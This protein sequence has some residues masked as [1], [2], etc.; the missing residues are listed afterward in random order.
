VIDLQREE[1]AGSR[2]ERERAAKTGA[3]LQNQLKQLQKQLARTGK[4]ASDT[5]SV[6][7]APTGLPAR[8]G[9]P[10]DTVSAKPEQS[11]LLQQ[12]NGAVTASSIRPREEAPVGGMAV[13]VPATNTRVRVSVRPGDTLWSIAQRH[14]VPVN[15]L[16]AINQLTDNRIQVGQALWLTEPVSAGEREHGNAE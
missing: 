10:S 4:Q 13:P 7:L 6:G 3:A 1:L 16:M 2:S 14:H 12:S 5:R 8:G 11:A 15:R 9:G